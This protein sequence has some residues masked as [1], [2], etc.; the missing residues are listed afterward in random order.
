MRRDII[1]GGYWL[2]PPAPGASLAI[3]YCGAVAEEALAAHEAILEDLPDAGLLA[4]TS[5]D[6]LNAEWSAAEQARQSGTPRAGSHVESLLAPMAP[7]A[8]IV[9]VLDGHP[10]SLAWLGA[11]RGHKVQ[12][13]GVEHFG[14]S[15]D[16]PDLFRHHRIDQD[17][18]LD[19]CAAALLAR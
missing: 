13:L 9:T 11:V 7:D 1:R 15:G 10:A 19:A 3:A 17:A 16:I 12:A 5:A 8:G 4:I 2:R 6:R 18:I 14:Q